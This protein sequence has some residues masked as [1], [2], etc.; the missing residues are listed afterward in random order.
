MTTLHSRKS[1]RRSPLR[2]GFFL[3]ALAVAC[4]ALLPSTGT[5][6]CG[7]GVGIGGPNF[8]FIRFNNVPIKSPGQCTPENVLLFGTLRVNFEVNEKDK[9]RP[10]TT[11]LENFS[12][13]GL[14]TQR[15]YVANNVSI[16]GLE[17]RGLRSGTKSGTG[18]FNLIVRVN[19]TANSAFGNY[20][21][22]LKWTVRYTWNDEGKVDYFALYD[23]S[24][25]QCKPEARCPVAAP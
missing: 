13:K 10:E 4:F 15:P 11:N 12:G 22:E 23:G 14:T 3:T 6:E 5:A 19:A 7:R 16:Q 18:K 2:L 20:T 24:E 8:R 25:L 9:V 17:L 1:I 21:F